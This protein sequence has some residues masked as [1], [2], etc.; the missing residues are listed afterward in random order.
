MTNSDAAQP[1][2]ERQPGR[3]V[4]G[5]Q[6]ETL[7]SIREVCRVCRCWR[8]QAPMLGDERFDSLQGVRFRYRDYSR[9]THDEFPSN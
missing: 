3:R 8:R 7:R 1:W 9:R 4:L 6:A 2:R 5:D